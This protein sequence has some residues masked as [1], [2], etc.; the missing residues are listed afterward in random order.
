[1]IELILG[2]ARSGKSRH[3]E[4]LVID[5]GKKKYY[6]ATA[7]AHDEEM[8]SRIEI[9]QE[10]R[11]K[12]W[13]VIEQPFTLADTLSEHDHEDHCI[14][15]DCLTLWLSNLLHSSDKNQWQQEKIKLLNKLTD[16]RGH[17]L[18]VSNEVGC[19]ITPMGEI[20]RQYVDELGWLHQDIA[21]TC[22]R[23]TLVTAGIPSVLKG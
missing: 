19:G 5:S 1:M 16:L 3:A 8:R 11:S 23:V 12:D 6:I 4:Q 13:I 10:R 22:D 2:G 7:Q 21:N 18:F 15:I 14:L 20:T 17:I 9:H